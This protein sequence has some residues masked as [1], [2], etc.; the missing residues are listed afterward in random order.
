MILFMEKQTQSICGMNNTESI[1][2]YI[3]YL[4]TEWKMCVQHFRQTSTT[5]ITSSAEHLFLLAR[6]NQMCASME[7]DKHRFMRP[8]PGA[9][10]SHDFYGT[11]L[12]ALINFLLQ[13]HRLHVSGRLLLSI[14][15]VPPLH[16]CLDRREPSNFCEVILL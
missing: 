12:G 16:L 5:L 4:Q 15:M 7:G 13:S 14:L 10:I 9:D 2:F 11:G 3:M 6:L 1:Q 8:P